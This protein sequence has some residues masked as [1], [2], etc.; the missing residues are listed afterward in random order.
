MSEKDKNPRLN[1]NS[2]PQSSRQLPFP[3]NLNNLISSPALTIN[4]ST[5]SL[6]YGGFLHPTPSS[7]GEH[8]T[9]PLPSCDSSLSP[10]QQLVVHQISPSTQNLQHGGFVHWSLYSRGH[11]M[12]AIP[13]GS[14]CISPYGA[15]QQGLAF[16]QTAP[17][18][19][20]YPFSAV[21]TWHS[22]MSPH[23]YEVVDLKPCVKNC[24]GRG[25]SFADKYRNSPYN[26]VVKHVDR[27]VTGKN[28]YTGLY[29]RDFSNTLPVSKKPHPEEKI[30][31]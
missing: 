5:P 25:T 17:V 26:L 27:R 9:T 10:P 14:S 28:E 21:V 8:L 29:S 6:Q 2:R 23:N 15:P 11:L 3:F 13:S 18:A 30:Q 31:S 16:Q 4:N 24:Y 7:S 22:G 12:S 19:P 20:Q 1:R